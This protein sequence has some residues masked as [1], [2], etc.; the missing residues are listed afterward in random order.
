MR[1]QVVLKKSF[2]DTRARGLRS[3]E[4]H[5]GTTL[6]SGDEWYRLQVKRVEYLFCSVF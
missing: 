3:A 2:N 6:I 5:T 4:D 1:L